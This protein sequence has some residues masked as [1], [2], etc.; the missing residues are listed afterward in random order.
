MYSGRSEFRVQDVQYPRQAS[1]EQFWIV[2]YPFPVV[3]Q[4]DFSASVSCLGLSLPTDS[5]QFRG[6]HWNSTSTAIIPV[7]SATTCHG[8]AD[9]AVAA[10]LGKK[11]IY[12]M[13]IFTKNMFL[14]EDR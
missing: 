13:N 14:A 2:S 8:S 5:E 11:G 4:A 1:R 7:S 3:D 12:G 6:S 9:T 10:R